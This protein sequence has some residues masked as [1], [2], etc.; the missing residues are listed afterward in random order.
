MKS[1][2]NLEIHFHQADNT[3]KCSNVKSVARTSQMFLNML[4]YFKYI[5][6]NDASLHLQCRN[7]RLDQYMM[8]IFKV[9]GGQSP[10]Q[11]TL[12]D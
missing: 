7:F 5:I 2:D 1:S 8:G 4:E 11:T 9:T 10:S 12:C 3:H 6:K